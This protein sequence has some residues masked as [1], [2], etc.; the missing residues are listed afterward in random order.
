MALEVTEI[1]SLVITILFGVLL[2]LFVVQTIKRKRSALALVVSLF[3]GLFAG[4][5]AIF[6]SGKL[7]PISGD[8]SDILMSL[9]LNLYGVQFFFFYIFLE[10]LISKDL[11][12]KRFAVV[13]GLLLMQ[14]FSLWLIV[15]FKSYDPGVNFQLWLFADLGY[16]LS[17][18]FVYLLFGLPI[19]LK[20][21]FYTRERK[22][23][24]FSF[25]MMLVGCGFILSLFSDYYDYI[26]SYP[27]WASTLDP[28]T[29]IVFVIGLLIFTITYLS[30]INYIYR[31]PNDIFMLMVLTKAGIPLYSVKLKSRKKVDI[32]GDLL[33]GMLSAI[34]NVFEAIFQSEAT[35]R[36]ISSEN[37][38]LLMEPGEEIVSAVITDK[39]SFFLVQSLKR[40]TKEF[41]T[42][43]LQ[44]LK[45]KN[46]DIAIYRGASEIIKPIFPFLI[47]DKESI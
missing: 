44:E 13:F 28:L 15:A 9:Q 16:T 18:L 4:I 23:M 22:P 45:D 34:N 40:Y 8:L 37:V 5:T 26:G 32:E 3:F 46:R 47:I 35:I 6:Q 41:E 30:D 33:S 31:L 12:I 21:Y 14:T 2:A 24:I 25:A 19:Y 29:N 7:I 17:G 42:L 20:T 36:S 10:C 39:P 1:A 43:F 27:E 38:H 11:N